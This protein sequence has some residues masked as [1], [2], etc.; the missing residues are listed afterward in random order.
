MSKQILAAP[1]IVAAPEEVF[2]PSPYQQADMNSYFRMAGEAVGFEVG[3]AGATQGDVLEIVQ[4]ARSD[5][6]EVQK[7][8][9]EELAYNPNI[10]VEQRA[11]AARLYMQ[12]SMAANASANK[13]KQAEVLFDKKNEEAIAFRT[14]VLEEE[15][16]RID[17]R[18]GTR[19]EAAKASNNVRSKKEAIAVSTAMATDDDAKANQMLLGVRKEADKEYYFR[20]RM[21]GKGG[22]RDIF[23]TAMELFPGAFTHENIV[24]FEVMDTSGVASLKKFAADYKGAGYA[25][26]FNPS[27]EGSGKVKRDAAKLVASLSPAEKTQLAQHM[28]RYMKQRPWQNINGGRTLAL[29]NVYDTLLADIPSSADPVKETDDWISSAIDFIGAE[30]VDKTAS[31]LDSVATVVD[32][33]PFFA[34]VGRGLANTNKMLRSAARIAPVSRKA[35][36]NEVAAAVRAGGKGVE[37]DMPAMVAAALPKSKVTFD[38]SNIS[39]DLNQALEDIDALTG[40]IE[41]QLMDSLN[42]PVAPISRNAPVAVRDYAKSKGLHGS[43]ASSVIE[44]SEDRTSVAITG[45]FGASDNAGY[46]SLDAAKEAI[47]KVGLD[48]FGDVKY[49]LRD[50]NSGVIYSE[51]DGD[52]YKQAQELASSK[53]GAKHF[54]W[55]VDTN[56]QVPVN[57]LI[58]M[59][60][61]A[62]NVIEGMGVPAYRRMLFTSGWTGLSNFYSTLSGKI[63]NGLRTAAG[64]ERYTEDLF[65]SLYNNSTNRIKASEWPAVNNAMRKTQEYGRTLTKDELYALKVESDESIAGYYG[66]RRALEVSRSYG[67]RGL[68]R[69]MA[70]EGW[71]ALRS[72]RGSLMSYA[73]EVEATPILKDGEAVRFADETGDEAVRTLSPAAMAALKEQGYKLYENQAIDWAG[74]LEVAYTAVKTTDSKVS[75][76]PVREGDEVLKSVDGYFPEILND[77]YAVY[78]VSKS[79]RRYVVATSKSLAVAQD[80]VNKEFAGGRFKEGSELS[81]KYKELRAEPFG[82]AY[83]QPIQVRAGIYE[84]LNSLVY[85]KKGDDIVSLDGPVGSNYTDPLDA[86][87]TTF[88][89]LADNYTKGS[90]IQFLENSLIRSLSDYPELL[91]TPEDTLRRGVVGIDDLVQKPPM[92]LEK[93]WSEIVST[94]KTIEGYKLLPDSTVQATSQVAEYLAM[95]STRFPVV[96][97]MLQRMSRSGVSPLNLWKKYRYFT[98]MRMNP[99]THYQL[100]AMQAAINAGWPIS[101][102]KAIVL[103]GVFQKAL[104]ARLDYAAGAISKAEMNELIKSTGK[105]GKLAG[106]TPEELSDLAEAYVTSGLWSQVRHNSLMKH[107]AL[108]DAER[109]S[110]QRSGAAVSFRN[111]ATRALEAADSIGAPAGEHFATQFTFL[112]QY[113]AIR[114]KNKRLLK[115]P[116]GKA[117]L[118]AR[119]QDFLGNMMPE[120]QLGVQRGFLSGATQFLS[121][122][123]KMQLAMTPG[124]QP[125]TM[126]AID[127]LRL[128]IGAIPMFG[129][130]AMDTAAFAYKTWLNNYINDPEH[131]ERVEA[132]ENSAVRRDAER[133]IMSSMIDRMVR[134]MT[135]LTFGGDVEDI[136]Y[137]EYDPAS[138]VGTGANLALTDAVMESAEAFVDAFGDIR[139]GNIVSGAGKAAGTILGI[140]GSNSVIDVAT[141]YVKLWKNTAPEQRTFEDLN[142]LANMAGTDG[143]NKMIPLMGNVERYMILNKYGELFQNGVPT[144]E[145]GSGNFSDFYYTVLLGAQ[146]MSDSDYYR[147]KNSI[148]AFKTKEEDYD[149]EVKAT[150]DGLRKYIY[151]EVL[152]EGLSQ[153]LQIAAVEKF[154]AGL[155][156][157]L[158]GMDVRFADD[159]QKELGK[160][161]RSDV[162]KETKEGRL[163]RRYI[164]EINGAELNKKGYKRVMEIKNSG[165]GRDDAEFLQSLAD[166]YKDIEYVGGED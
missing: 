113:F 20:P 25:K 19:R 97:E 38:R 158:S 3:D 66:L 88:R 92:H 93:Q 160:Q 87:Y 106:L 62:E 78:G 46:K 18:N 147:A 142:K 163:A 27:G 79:G 72:N 105:Y 84:N 7:A 119:T 157:R 64:A 47:A 102:G 111:L 162:R 123:A 109:I 151:S 94:I 134:A 140:R 39:V 82:S 121:Y 100:N 89:L 159:V 154:N 156:L 126:T 40:R 21:I 34:I 28:S 150:V 42:R 131:P 41:T 35:V 118:L 152:V 29:Q 129:W 96:Q 135:Y 12:L 44:I 161:L 110:G 1:T 108:N 63:V 53:K 103:H 10:P 127:S 6:T 164:G 149:K 60:G 2:T 71:V 112:A 14:G 120:G 80:F 137:I 122:G 48:G 50:K 43:P 24:L 11:D 155:S 95:K 128:S 51:A 74:S 49:S 23:N 75:V 32:P 91:R 13:Y 77:N 9:L 31:V 115:T 85:G 146:T 143:L 114:G 139:S 22:G 99:T 107:S 132:W 56:Y 58:Y 8:A 15:G 144:G 52:I 153:E 86:I 141:R 76:R 124:L 57:K 166:Y 68:G 145:T 81:T 45:R 54:E 59:D 117:Q 116:E 101:S 65:K 138:R 98:V 4:R 70:S 136:D 133:G 26:L 37:E 69:T 61:L 83:N 90:Q 125:T 165:V 73:K 67:N 55:F 104:F 30:T 36:A 16:P 5:E 17:E 148:Q 33:I 130:R